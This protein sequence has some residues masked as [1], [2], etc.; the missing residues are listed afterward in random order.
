MKLIRP[1]GVYAP[2]GDSRLLLDVLLAAAIP[3]GARML[4][5]CTGT[6]VL[7][8]AGARLGAGEV[9]AVDISLRAAFAAGV[10]ARMRGLP[11]T[12]R[13]GDYLT[14]AAGRRFDVVTAN[15]PYVPCPETGRRRRRS[16]RA[17]DAGEDGRVHLDRLCAAAPGLLAPDGVLLMVHSALCG[18]DLTLE[19]M[20]RSGLKAT[21]VARRRQ[22]FGPVLHSRAAWLED[23]GLIAPGQREEELVII[24]AD[25]AVASVRDTATA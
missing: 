16:A 13:R 21:V 24:R 10:N 11:I 20:R 7:A 19:R 12:V 6:G 22:A 2:Q 1:P 14:C 25:H 5:V 3:A 18:P 23:R 4:D 17:W 8:I 9:H 15:P